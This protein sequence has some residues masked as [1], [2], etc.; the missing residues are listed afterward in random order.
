VGE[1]IGLIRLQQ[2]LFNYNKIPDMLIFYFSKV[3]SKAH[4]ISIRSA[5][6]YNISNNSLMLIANP[7]LQLK[8]GFDY[9]GELGLESWREMGKKQ[10]NALELF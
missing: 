8:F 7:S 5:F 2:I 3:N 10:R 6:S 9:F 4:P 1:Q